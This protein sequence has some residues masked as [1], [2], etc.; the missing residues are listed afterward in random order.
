MPQSKERNTQYKKQRRLEGKDEKPP[1]EFIA[2]DGESSTLPDG[3][4]VYQMMGAYGTKLGEKTIEN[5]EG[6]S[7]VEAL[8]F[9][10]SLRYRRQRLCICGYS[11]GYDISLI[12]KDLRIGA[13]N[14]LR[15]DKTAGLYISPTM[16]Y[17]IRVIH[18]KCID[19]YK[20]EKID[21]KWKCIGF[22]KV[23]DVFGFFQTSFLKAIEEW[24]VGSDEEKAIVKE[25]KKRRGENLEEDWEGWKRYNLTE[26]RLLSA[27]MKDFSQ[28]CENAGIKLSNWWGAGAIASA[29]MKD[30]RIK[31]HLQTSW[32]DETDSWMK[33]AFFG[34]QIQ[35]LQVGVFKNP[36]YHYDIN[37]AYPCGITQLPSLK[38]GKWRETDHFEPDEQWA[39]YDIQWDFTPIWGSEQHGY[40]GP[41]PWRTA[42]SSILYMSKGWGVY[43]Y[44]EVAAVLRYWPQYVKVIRGKIF[45]P[46]IETKPFSWVIDVFNERNR[47][48]QAGDP[49]NIPL[50]LGLN[51][52]YGKCAQKQGSKD[53][54]GRLIAPPYKSDFWS[55]NI[56]SMSRAKI[57]DAVG[58]NPSCVIAVA[59][60]GLFTTQPLPLPTSKELGA[61]S[62]E[63]VLLKFEL[64]ANGVY[65]GMYYD[66]KKKKHQL[67]KKARGIEDRDFKFSAFRKQFLATPPDKIRTMCHHY[68]LKRFHGYRTA[69][70]RNKPELM[71][72]WS[73]DDRQFFIIG[74]DCFHA[75]PTND[76][77]IYRIESYFK[78]HRE[79]VKNP[80]RF[81]REYFPRPGVDED[82]LIASE[83][84]RLS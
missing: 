15:Q 18:R 50:K 40:Y 48:K 70:H 24:K 45:E 35:R 25:F 7:T 4:A 71:N 21:R 10:L 69:L 74:M 36:V 26:C 30:H 51:S 19:I 53:A 63:P 44:W 11:F 49:R 28:V 43:W 23:Y 9:L 32:D 58:S 61:W 56:T 73:I 47:L 31:D 66:E 79:K 3:K 41:L 34:G 13:L 57:I 52:L 72:T 83:Q 59:T 37:S 12:L 14:R 75:F 8:E 76:P 2:V 20:M 39:L 62:E 84:P 54:Q 80:A 60:D 67:L 27:M 65:R 6:I 22:V 64:F 77:A 1:W 55:G 16:R 33:R 68:K 42:K 46:A 82:S 78:M 38:G 17:K 81:E 29:M 5:K